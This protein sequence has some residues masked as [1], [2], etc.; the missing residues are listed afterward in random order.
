MTETKLASNLLQQQAYVNGEWIDAEDGRCFEIR[1][2]VDGQVLA[3]VADCGVAETRRAIEA[4][5]AALPDWQTQTA[6]ARADIL[7]RWFD[8]VMQHQDALAALLTAEQGKVLSE[9]KGEIAYGAHYLEWFAEEAKRI[10]GDILAA[11]S[12]DQR[13]LV[14]KRPVG[15]VAAITPWNFPNAML[16]RKVAAALAVGCTFVAKPAKETPLSALA[17]AALGEEAG[18]PPGVFN[19]VCGSDSSVIGGELT[20]NPIVRKLTF[21]GSTATG[22]KLM[23]QCADTV[24]RTSM[25]LGGN[26]P[27]IVFDDADLDAAVAGAMAAKFRNAGQTCVCANRLLVHAD[28]YD[29]FVDRLSQETEKFQLGNGADEAVTMGPL[30]RPSAVDSVQA[31][32]SEALGAGAVATVGG[33]GSELGDCFYQPTVLRDCAPSMRC[34]KEEIFGPVA[35]VFKFETEA[36]AIQLANDTEFGL[37]AYFY[38]RDYARIWRVSESLDYGMVGINEAAISNPMAPF[39]GVK[40]S[41]H[42]REGSKYGVDDYIETKYLCMGGL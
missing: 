37:A 39:G 26:A 25:E 21:T 28:V 4:A 2:P 42:G 14:L 1:N 32:V 15:V 40:E 19:V 7:R 27:F 30:I 16:A 12:Q 18:L 24:K 29:A 22:K 41:G 9:A 35:P 34:F 11:P 20:A 8:L 33:Q 36:E 5:E 6:K 10:D 38:S 3:K 17:L 13:V 31:I 23:Q